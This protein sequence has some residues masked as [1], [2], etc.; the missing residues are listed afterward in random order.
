MPFYFTSQIDKLIEDKRAFSEELNAF[1]QQKKEL[2]KKEK[3][4]SVKQQEMDIKEQA[5]EQ[6][7][8]LDSARNDQRTKMKASLE[9]DV[10]EL[11]SQFQSLKEAI[12]LL[13]STKAAIKDD[14][15]HLIQRKSKLQEEITDSES[16]FS[17]ARGKR[18]TRLGKYISFLCALCLS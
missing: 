5:L 3:Q 9:K 8:K 18:E 4:L 12:E 16:R 17:S 6:S 2:S 14:L 1:E 10:E 13:T 15:E 11:R 7:E